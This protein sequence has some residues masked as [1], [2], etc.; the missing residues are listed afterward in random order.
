MCFGKKDCL[1]FHLA[2]GCW[3][4]RSRPV[5]CGESLFLVCLRASL[6][7]LWN[8][9]R[10]KTIS[11]VE[12]FFLPLQAKA[13]RGSH[14]IQRQRRVKV[15]CAIL[16]PQFIHFVWTHAFVHGAN[17]AVANC[18]KHV[19]RHRL[20]STSMSPFSRLFARSKQNNNNH[21]LCKIHFQKLNK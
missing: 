21:L 12:Y 1:L 18:A 16:W 4:W 17:G 7:F 10:A 11:M 19:N 3:L 15:I 20:P 5:L 2:A 14:G 6:D 13:L 8:V 9:L